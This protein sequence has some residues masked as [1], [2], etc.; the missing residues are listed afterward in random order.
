MGLGSIR[1]Q[2][3]VDFSMSYLFYSQRAFFSD[4]E[5]T[6]PHRE[7]PDGTLTVVEFGFERRVDLWPSNCKTDNLCWLSYLTIQRLAHNCVIDGSAISWHRQSSASL[8]R[9]TEILS[10]T[11]Y[12][13]GAV[14][15]IELTIWKIVSSIFHWPGISERFYSNSVPGKRAAKAM[16]SNG[17]IVWSRPHTQ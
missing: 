9:G 1:G 11:R 17:Q 3:P 2:A 14:S 10:S 5:L 4:R 7:T 12:P 16:E 13:G 15:S 6:T 8:G